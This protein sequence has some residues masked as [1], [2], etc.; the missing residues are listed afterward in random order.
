MGAVS[1]AIRVRASQEVGSL[2]SLLPSRLCHVLGTGGTESENAPDVAAQSGYPLT[3]TLGLPS[4][5]N[6]SL[7]TFPVLEWQD[8]NSTPNWSLG[9]HRCVCVEGKAAGATDLPEPVKSLHREKASSWW[10]T[11]LPAVALSPP[12]GKATEDIAQ[13]PWALSKSF[14]VSVLNP[15][16]SH[17]YFRINCS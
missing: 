8:R 4:P 6:M 9:K 16:P 11:S 15:V 2:S 3:Y 13:I 5:Q 12:R 17:A 10:A 1:S 14:A 7:V